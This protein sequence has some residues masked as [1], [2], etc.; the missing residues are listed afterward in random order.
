MTVCESVEGLAQFPNVLLISDRVDVS[1]MVAALEPETLVIYRPR[2]LVVGIG[3]RRGVGVAEVEG[4]LR[5]HSRQSS[6]RWGAF[7]ASLRRN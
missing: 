7:G 3:S 5:G 6:L 1:D 4:L 2:S